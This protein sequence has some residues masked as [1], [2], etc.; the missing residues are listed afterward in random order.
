VEW[1]DFAIFGALGVVLVPAFFPSG[2]GASTLL[3][4]FAVYATAFLARPLGAVFWGRRG[5]A[6]GRQG[7]LASV[8][9]TMTGATA[10][11][12]L[13][14]SHARIG[15]LAGVVVVLLRVIQGLAA[16]GEL[17]LAAVF[18][19]EHAAIQRRGMVASWHTATLALG[20]GLG[21]GVGALVLALAPDDGRGGWWRIPFLVA[22]P[23]G[24]AGFY[25]RRRVSETPS[26]RRPGPDHDPVARPVRV[27]WRERRPALRA[28]FALIAAGSLAFNAWFV[29]LPNHLVATTTRGLPSALLASVGGLML[30]AVAAVALGRLS[31]RIGRRPVVLGSVGALALTV[32]PLWLLAT[33]GSFV[34]L[35][36]AQSSAAV[37]IAGALSEATLA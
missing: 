24:L 14:P 2:D 1:Y 25:V 30:S 11:I 23:L 21:F 12:G 7:V 35:L 4:A 26:F 32:V 28:G 27:V 36:V 6:R 9:L 10:A 19:A 5:D 3:A 13:A 29:F 18:I 15:V 16:G 31:D 20:V 37:A 8:V 33:S 34:A 22:L 17:G